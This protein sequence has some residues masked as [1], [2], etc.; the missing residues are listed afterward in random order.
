MYWNELK[1]TWCYMKE[2]AQM[3]WTS[4]SLRTC[5]VFN[6]NSW[7]VGDNDI[8]ACWPKSQNLEIGQ[9]LRI[10]LIYFPHTHTHTRTHAH[11]HTYTHTHTHT[12]KH[13]HTHTRYLLPLMFYRLHHSCLKWLRLS[14][15]TFRYLDLNQ[16]LPLRAFHLILALRVSFQNYVPTVF[17]NY[18]AS[19]EIDKQRIELNMWDTSGKTRAGFGVFIFWS[20]QRDQT[21]DSSE[22]LDEHLGCGPKN[23]SEPQLECDGD[24][25]PGVNCVFLSNLI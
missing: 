12:H 25:Q 21:A 13:T 18:T 19:F 14:F 11:T 1:F 4:I 23:R 6:W 16:I 8:R 17:E 20:C 2:E 24:N 15:S 10:G 5:R 7:S 9:Q 3:Q 22:C